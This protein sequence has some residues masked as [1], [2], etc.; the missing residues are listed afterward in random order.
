MK[1][2]VFRD[3]THC[4]K[5]FDLIT[6]RR[7]VICSR[8]QGQVDAARTKLNVADVSLGVGIVSL[9]A[10][11]WFFFHRGPAPTATALDLR[12]DVEARPGGAVATLRATF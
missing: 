7:P 1:P 5:M 6:M 4:K 12:P 8:T 10:A 3:L 9:A 2:D 11:A